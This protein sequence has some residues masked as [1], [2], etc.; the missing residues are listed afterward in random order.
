MFDV[1]GGGSRDR[2]L[3]STWLVLVLVLGAC[4]G[5][6][7]PTAVQ[8]PLDRSNQLALDAAVSDALLSDPSMHDWATE[9]V[10]DRGIN[11]VG[12][13]L[14]QACGAK[15]ASDDRIVAEAADGWHGPGG[16]P[17]FDQMVL[18][19]DRASAS[20]A[21]RQAYAALTCRTYDSPFSDVSLRITK[22]PTWHGTEEF[23]FCEGPARGMGNYRCVAILGAGSISCAVRVLAADQDRADRLLLGL[24]PTARTRC[25]HQ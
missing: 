2:L 6:G 3:A 24:L 21:V 12:Y 1:T 5:P 16:M 10:G 23:G 8:P 9:P 25:V 22:G 19:Y 14:L 7:E 20:D 18:G 4:R 17:V 15:L 13:R 11:A